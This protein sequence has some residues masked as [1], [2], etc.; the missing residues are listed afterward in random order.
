[1]K[2][3]TDD[4]VGQ[5]ADQVKQFNEDNKGLVKAANEAKAYAEGIKKDY[6]EKV[7]ELNTNL[8]AK[9][10]TILQIQDSVKELKAKQG[11]LGSG[12][13]VPATSVEELIA[14]SFESEEA[15][16]VLKQGRM[17]TPWFTDKLPKNPR[18]KAAG[19]ITVSGNVTG[20]S[21]GSTPTWSDQIWGAERGDLHFRDLFRI[22]DSATGTFT[23]YRANTPSG[24]GSVATVQPAG[25]KPLIDKDLSIQT[26]TAY[27]KAGV[28]DIAKESLQ[29]VPMLQSYLNEELVNDYL[30]TETY[31]MFVALLAAANGSGTIPVGAT[32]TVEKLIHLIKNQRKSKNRFDRLIVK[33]DI[34]AETILTKPNDYS[35]PNVVTVLPNGQVA[36]LGVPMSVVNTD[37]LTDRQ[38]L[39]GDS[40]KAAIMQV[41]GEGLKLELFKQHDKA[42]YQNLVSLRVEARVAPI[43]FRTEAFIKATLAAEA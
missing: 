17:E 41:I 14:K 30:D 29:D 18:W 4:L 33:P 32:K 21:I 26:A 10:A 19:T 23:Y 3:T 7:K 1:M 43:I 9:D 42:V 31:D 5:L 27:Y 35:T 40:R 38:V 39:I 6:E 37:A 34:W 36:I 11:S 15:I 12:L 16:S 2:T 24:E 25:Q 28:A 22:I 13:I 8:A 20:A